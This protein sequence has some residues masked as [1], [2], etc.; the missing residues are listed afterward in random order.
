MK[1]RIYIDEV[2]NSDLESS[3]NPNHRFLSLTGVIMELGHVEQRVFPQLEALKTKFFS[4]HPDEP[5]ILHRKEIVNHKQPFQ[6]LRDPAVQKTF[7]AELLAL[8]RAWDYAVVSVCID[9]RNHRDVYQVWRY[10]PY[11]YCLAV[12][13]ER[14]FFFL[15][16][17]GSRGDVMAESRGGKEDLRLKA[18]FAKLWED[19]TEYI[20][21]EKF[22]AVLTS[23]Q[24]K[25]KPKANNVA[26]LQL[27]DLLAHPSRNE[28][29]RDKGFLEEG[30]RPFGE[31]IVAIL[32][33]KYYRR[34]TRV[35][36][37]KFI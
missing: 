32:Q 10:D 22:H 34:G 35:F 23:K 7:D 21:A 28:M 18:S 11:H 37:K 5:V 13:M 9:K 8:L 27:A 20:P 16:E 29:L 36:G 30:L 33:D 19:G 2:G 3:D 6:S 4:S 12:L 25:V 15:N 26:G 14:Y 1:Y 17:R 31:K 24:L